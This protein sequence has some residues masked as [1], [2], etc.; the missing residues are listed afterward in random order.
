LEINKLNNELTIKALALHESRVHAAK[1]IEEEVKLLLGDL[2][3]SNTQFVFNL[4]ILED[5]NSTGVTDIR[6]LFSA[7]RGIDP[8]P[9]E[10]AA[11]GGELSRVML[12]IQKLLAHKKQLP[13][14]LFDEIDTGVS[15][16]VA[17]NIGLLLKEMGENVQLIAIT[18]LPQVA[19]KARNHFK[20]SKHQQND[21]TNVEVNFLNPE[22]RVSEV[23]RLMSGELITA[24]AIENAKYLMA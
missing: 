10:K 9:I 23:A 13:T 2:K 18:H 6:M 3:M 1:I 14:V 20:V 19:A 15:G 4:N 7:N 12:S 8:I 24:A 21:Q 22:Q 5:F 11:S 16:E 17:H